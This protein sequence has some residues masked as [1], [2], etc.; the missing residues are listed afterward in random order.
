MCCVL[1]QL[2]N[3][4]FCL[5]NF[6]HPEMSILHDIKAHNGEIDDIDFH[7]TSKMVNHHICIFS[8]ISMVLWLNII[9]FSIY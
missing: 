2:N 7:P 5:F 3:S 6:Q 4:F 1:I 8:I 9:L